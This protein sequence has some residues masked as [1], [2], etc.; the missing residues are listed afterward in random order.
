[1]NV[2]AVVADQLDWTSVCPLDALVPERG[3]AALVGGHQIALFRV[4]EPDGPRIHA[5]GHHDPFSRANVMAR[6]LI[7]SR[8][9]VLTVASPMYKQVFDLATGRCLD[10]D[11]VQL[12]VWATRVADGM[13]QVGIPSAVTLMQ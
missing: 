2:V 8:G 6:G 11:A 12:P 10:D 3:V 9:D 1:M 13:V 5:V 4:D 7:G